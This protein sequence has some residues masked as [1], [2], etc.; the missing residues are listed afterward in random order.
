MGWMTDV[1]GHEGYLIGLVPESGKTIEG[2]REYESEILRELTYHRD[3]QRT[4][5]V[6]LR[7]VCV[8][9]DCGW[10]SPRMH[11]PSGTEW[12]PCHVWLAQ[13]RDESICEGYEES[14]RKIWLA[15]VADVRK[16]GMPILR[17]DEDGLHAA[18]DRAVAR[19]A[20]ERNRNEGT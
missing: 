5:T 2:G 11:A 7:Y 9:C 15:H 6:P 20:A 10:R 19:R 8:G 12:T 18:W 14:A 1:D 3:G 16:N 4:D 17:V 13:G